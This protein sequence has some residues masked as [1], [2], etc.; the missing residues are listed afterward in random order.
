MGG[1][2]G[3]QLIRLQMRNGRVVGEEKLLEDRC[4]RTKDVREGP[5]G[6]IY[7][8]TDETPSE[9]LRLTPKR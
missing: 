7:V 1:M 5:D 8:V 3:R 2:S 6:A 4:K 9:I